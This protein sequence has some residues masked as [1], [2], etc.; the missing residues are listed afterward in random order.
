MRL[1]DLRLLFFFV[2]VV[3]VVACF[4]PRVYLYFFETGTAYVFLA[5]KHVFLCFVLS[6][7]N[8][9]RVNVT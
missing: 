9:V 2:V 6:F 8:R 4:G 3:A 5:E 7:I 1:S